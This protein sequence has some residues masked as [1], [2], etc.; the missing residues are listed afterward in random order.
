MSWE[1]MGQV[2]IWRSL[3]QGQGH[4]SKTGW[5]S[6]FPQCKTS[7][8]DNSGSIKHRATKF[9]CCTGFSDMVD[10]MVWP[11][12]LSRDQ[13]WPCLIKCSHSRVVGL[14]LEDNVVSII[15]TVITLADVIVQVNWVD[16]SASKWEGFNGSHL[17]S[18][19]WIL[20]MVHQM[21]LT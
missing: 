13:K 17:R 1:D 2:H 21:S 12:S 16:V 6:I 10:W 3:G 9:A 4:R 5:K 18:W 7:D 11:P 20:V 14:R 15:I 8:S 19:R